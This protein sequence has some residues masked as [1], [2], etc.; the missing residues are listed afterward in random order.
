MSLSKAREARIQL[1]KRPHKR[2][3][4]GFN[5]SAD[6]SGGRYYTSPVILRH[7]KDHFSRISFELTVMAD[8]DIILPY[9]WLQQHVPSEYWD[10][11]AQKIRFASDY[12]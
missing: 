12:C 11:D 4:Y 3:L 5:D 6:V 10:G 9:W 7:A 2:T 8:C 1:N